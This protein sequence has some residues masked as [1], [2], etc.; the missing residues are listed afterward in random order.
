MD[1][2]QSETYIAQFKQLSV[3]QQAQAIKILNEAYT[4][5]IGVGGGTTRGQGAS[6]SAL[7]HRGSLQTWHHPRLATLSLCQR[8][9]SHLQCG[10]GFALVRFASQGE[11]AGVRGGTNAFGDGAQIGSQLWDRGQHCVS[12]ASSVSVDAGAK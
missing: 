3:H 8:L 1:A 10:V 2:E 6:L 4:E 9:W 11:V 5:S 12:L 7:W